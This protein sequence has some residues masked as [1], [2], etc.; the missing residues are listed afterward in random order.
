LPSLH[1][2]III[3]HLRSVI[4][5]SHSYGTDSHHHDHHSPFICTAPDIIILILDFNFS[6]PIIISSLSARRRLPPTSD[7]PSRLHL[8]GAGHNHH[9]HHLA[10]I[11]MA[12]AVAAIIVSPS[13]AWR[14]LPAPSS[15]RLHLH[16]ARRN[17]H[18]LVVI[19]TAPA[20]AVI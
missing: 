19:C 4:F 2:A 1:G 3:S 5:V 8:H 11:C 16:G 9:H 10:F 20:A 7:S 18:H 15:S 6:T 14:W 17:H 13:S 12:L